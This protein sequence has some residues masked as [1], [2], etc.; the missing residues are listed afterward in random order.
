MYIKGRALM[1]QKNT[2]DFQTRTPKEAHLENTSNTQP[3]IL[4]NRDS[5]I[6]MYICIIE[7]YRFNKSHTHIDEQNTLKTTEEK[8]EQQRINVDK[9]Y[10]KCIHRL[11]F[12]QL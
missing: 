12:Q 6:F 5:L 1:K 8:N 4:Y 11:K 7:I 2:I 10:V 3:C 9:T